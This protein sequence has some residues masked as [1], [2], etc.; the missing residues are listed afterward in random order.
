LQK[1][2]TLAK[3]GHTLS[4]DVRVQQDISEHHAKIALMVIDVY[5]MDVIWDDA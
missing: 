4:K 5:E 1:I 3:K 2:E